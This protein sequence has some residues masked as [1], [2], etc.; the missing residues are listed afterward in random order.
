MCLLFH[1]EFTFHN[2]WNQIH[3][4]NRVWATHI[5]QVHCYGRGFS[6]RY[7]SGSKQIKENELSEL[8]FI[9][10][11]FVSAI[12]IIKRRRC[13]RLIQIYCR[14]EQYST[15]YKIFQKRNITVLSTDNKI[16]QEMENADIKVVFEF[17]LTTVRHSSLKVA[18]NGWKDRCICKLQ[19]T[20]KRSGKSFLT[21]RRASSLF[22]APV[23]LIK[24]CRAVATLFWNVDVRKWT[25][26]SNSS[27]INFCTACIKQYK[28]TG[29]KYIIKQDS[30]HF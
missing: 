21:C 14:V 28:E 22:S 15:R 25:I 1:S 18:R 16:Q 3:P 20:K 24:S 6:Y 9:W 13:Q 27:S 19:R 2:N 7:W 23:S 29:L 11:I 10:I 30:L 5:S 17:Y 12:F 4:P 26:P 8:Q